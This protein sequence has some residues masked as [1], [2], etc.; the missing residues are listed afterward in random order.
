MKEDR[1]RIIGIFAHLDSFTRGIRDLRDSG[2]ADLVAFSPVPRHEI[3]EALEGGKS[4]VRVFTL[5]GGILGGLTGAALTI[6]ASL[7]YPLVTGGKP[8]ISIPPY[9]IIVFELTIL[10]GALATI[11]GM[12]INMRLPRLRLEPI[13]DPRFTEDRFGLSITCSADE[14]DRVTN[15]LRTAGAEEVRLEGA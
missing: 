9:L 13:Y 6:T 8:I 10:F 2:Y 15:A 12:L 3:E 1:V 5:I 14:V 4:P 11:L 7:H